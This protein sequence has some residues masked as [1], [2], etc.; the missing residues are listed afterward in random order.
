MTELLRGGAR[1]LIA[2]AVEAE[3]A[4]FLQSYQEDKDAQGRRQVVRNGY[5]PERDVQ[6]QLGS[7]KVQ[8]PQVSL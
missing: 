2:P 3:L 7:V 1:Q 6:T 5:L 4:E 8:V